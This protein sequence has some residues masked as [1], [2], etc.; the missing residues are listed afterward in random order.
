[1]FAFAE[2]GLFIAIG[3]IIPSGPPLG[4]PV[5]AC[6]AVE[7]RPLFPLATEYVFGTVKPAYLLGAVGILSTVE[8]VWLIAPE[9]SAARKRKD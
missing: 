8:T 6:S 1:M 3:L 2:F 9:A 4:K 7:S 5:S